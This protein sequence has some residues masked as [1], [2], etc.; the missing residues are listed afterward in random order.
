MLK[1]KIRVL[2]LKLLLPRGRQ[3]QHEAGIEVRWNKYFVKSGEKNLCVLQR[4][5]LDSA[6]GI[7]ILSHSYL[8]EAKKFYLTRGHAQMYL[9]QG[10]EVVIFDFNGFGE[11][12]FVDFDYCGDLTAV[13]DFI[14]KSN[15]GKPV[16]GHGVSFGASH[17]IT[18]GTAADN[19]FQRI[20]I[21]NCLDSNLS[22]YRKRNIKL[23]FMMLSLMKIFPAVN[24]DH[25]YING[26][27]NLKNIKRALFIYNTDDDLTT[28][29]MGEQLCEACNVTASM[30]IFSGQHLQAF[31]KN[32]DKY[33]EKVISF[34]LNI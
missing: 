19:V 29:K 32:P 10:F 21:E 5:V 13:A 33:T 7:I 15:P 9:D 6:K 34:L 22:Y 1:N 31:Q 2:T 27:K 25:N 28:I 8:A 11:S 12:P 20:I 30:E 14:Q 23:H 4:S 26:I 24:K 16:F 18:Y 3:Y 17:T